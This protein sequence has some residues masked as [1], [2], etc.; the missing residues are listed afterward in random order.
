MAG[1]READYLVTDIGQKL[2]SISDLAR[3]FDI[4][5]RTIR[6]YEDEGLLTPERAGNR[7][8]YAEA[9]KARLSWVLRARRVGFSLAEIGELLDLYSQDDGRRT[10]RVKTLEK[11]RERMSALTAQRDDLDKTLRELSA[12]CDLLDSLIDNPSLE[13]E[14]RRR[15]RDALGG[16]LPIDENSYG[17]AR[18]SARAG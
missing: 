10:Q 1:S 13:P 5:H 4:T 8:L 9:D 15:F 6:F 14:A 18:V 3:D 7:R 16:A 12:F 17:R 11:C 2:Y